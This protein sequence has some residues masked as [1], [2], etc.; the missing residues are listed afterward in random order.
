MFFQLTN[1]EGY[2]TFGKK[3]SRER[4]NHEDLELIQTMSH[5]L[6]LNLERIQLQEEIIREKAEKEKLREVNRLKTEFISSVSHEI[7]TPM[8]TI[9]GLSE[10]LQEGKVKD[11]KKRDELFR[12]MSSE[13]TRLSRFL[14]NILD[15]G[16][17]EKKTKTFHLE[18]AELIS[19]TK[20]TLMLQEYQIKSAG[21]KLKT[22]LPKGEILIDIDKDAVKQALINIID[23]AMKYSQQTKEIEVS[24]IERD[25]EIEIRVTDKGIG[26]SPGEQK[27]IFKDFYRTQEASQLSPKGVGLGLKIVKHIM[28]AHK[29]RIDVRSQAGEGSTFGLIFRK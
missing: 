17:I 9:Q 26:I 20:E 2:L 19:Q 1:L 10:L 15:F 5:E 12:L 22:H 3:R 28:D 21:F 27:K 23:N 6:A 4:Y 18:E 16:K 29:G 25:K 14:H 11:R 8:S 24:I 7:R 13:C